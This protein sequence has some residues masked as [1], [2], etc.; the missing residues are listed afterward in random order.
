MSY[1]TQHE[2][3]PNIIILKLMSHE[4]CTKSHQILPFLIP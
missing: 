3:D 4:K 1:K 2:F